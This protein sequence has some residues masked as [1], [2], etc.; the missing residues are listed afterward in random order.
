M[1]WF[2][3]DLSVCVRNNVSEPLIVQCCGIGSVANVDSQL[4]ILRRWLESLITVDGKLLLAVKIINLRLSIDRVKL[5]NTNALF[6]R[7]SSVHFALAR[8]GRVK[9]P[10]VST[11]NPD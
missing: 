6:R 11:T 9:R 2:P 5:S 8:L 10:V 1:G 4:A 7:G 3:K